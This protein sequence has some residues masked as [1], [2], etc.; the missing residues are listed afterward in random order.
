MPAKKRTSLDMLIAPVSEPKAATVKKSNAK[1]KKEAS[2][3]A[4]AKPT[5]DKG[6]VVKS[7]MYIPKPVYEQLR[8]LAFDERKK[9]HDY[10]V[11]GIDRVFAD[12]GLKPIAEL[13]GEG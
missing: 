8:N 2:E 7:S 11:E 10:V 5:E 12:R 13:L 9:I 1:P 3:T 4:A 6:D